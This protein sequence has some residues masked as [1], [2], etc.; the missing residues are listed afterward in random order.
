M[1]HLYFWGKITPSKGCQHKM[2]KPA[3]EP[4]TVKSYDGFRRYLRVYIY[5]VLCDVSLTRF[6]V[7]GF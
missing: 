4:V 6:G 2:N 5:I 3:I 7:I 1:L